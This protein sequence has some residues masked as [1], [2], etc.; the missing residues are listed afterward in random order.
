MIA[1][2]GP[3]LGRGH[4]RY[5]TD[6]TTVWQ[7]GSLVCGVGK[8]ISAFVDFVSPD[9]GT[10][11]LKLVSLGFEREWVMR[12]SCPYCNTIADTHKQVMR[13]KV[14]SLVIRTP[15]TRGRHA[16]RKRMVCLSGWRLLFLPSQ[17]KR[18][19]VL[20]PPLLFQ[21]PPAR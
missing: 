14:W 15:L 13:R 4:P 19:G 17:P 16:I 20:P 18:S 7:V 8:Q 10:I 21:Y 5:S 9:C 6:L 1:S 2:L 12:E 11:D 3:Y